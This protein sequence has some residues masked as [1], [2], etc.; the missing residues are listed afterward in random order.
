MNEKNFGSRL[1]IIQKNVHS[2][3]RKAAIAWGKGTDH[4]GH[5]TINPIKNFDLNK[6]IFYTLEGTLPRMVIEAKIAKSVQWSQMRENEIDQA[7]E[8]TTVTTAIAPPSPPQ[9]IQQ[10]GPA[11]PKKDKGNSKYLYEL[12]PYGPGKQACKFAGLP[13]PTGCV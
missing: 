3:Q 10:D 1:N 6:T 13:K 11:G 7:Y 9:V 2:L 5:V 4:K 12:F 8:A